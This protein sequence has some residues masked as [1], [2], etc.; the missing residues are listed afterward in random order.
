MATTSDSP[1]ALASQGW[2]KVVY[3]AEV[4]SDDACPQCGGDYS[5]CPCPGPTMDDEYDYQ[6]D[7]DGVLW[8]RKRD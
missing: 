8:A 1:Q 4:G 5:D 2:I 3:A 6:Q 7:A